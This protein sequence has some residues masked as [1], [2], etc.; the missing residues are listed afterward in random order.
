M[1]KD[2][3]ASFV[4]ALANHRV[5]C[6]ERYRELENKITRIEVHSA[7]NLKLLWLLLGGMFFVVA[8]TVWP[9]LT[10]GGV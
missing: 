4:R 7:R 10:G 5:E 9:F 6:S 2:D 3:E 8:R 1:G